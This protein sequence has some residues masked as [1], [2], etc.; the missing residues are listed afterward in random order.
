[1]FAGNTRAL[2]YCRSYEEAKKLF[3][4]TPQ[5]RGKDWCDWQRPLDDARKWHYRIERR[6]NPQAEPAYFD[7]CLFQQ[8]MA[9]YYKP[10]ADG[11]RRVLYS[12]DDRQTSHGFMHDV[13]QVSTGWEDWFTPDDRKV[14]VPLWTSNSI[15]DEGER[16]CA[17]LRFDAEGRLLVER[18]NHTGVYRKLASA[19]DKA[20]RKAIREAV[21]PF[22][23][24]A[25]MRKPEFE[26]EAAPN[27]GY[28]YGRRRFNG[29]DLD[30]RQT[31]A[32]ETLAR[33]PSKADADTMVAFFEA[34]HRIHA[35]LRDRSEDGAPP[36]PESFARALTE[37]LLRS[38]A[39]G[40]ERSGRVD[41]PKFHT[42]EQIGGTQSLRSE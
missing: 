5:P 8:V 22:V 1:M 11:T 6:G 13:L 34:A 35:F 32:G 37:W 23:T 36:T 16:F 7:I 40:T 17:D 18:S 39:E 19:D 10:E 14:F 30:W 24:L 25:L 33:N 28:R 26:T 41:L 4:K 21:Q 31:K 27:G 2:P 20:T 3:D 42:E 12:S 29:Y 38:T 9:R 15:Y